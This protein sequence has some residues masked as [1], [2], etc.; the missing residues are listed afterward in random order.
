MQFL[1]GLEQKMKMVVQRASAHF[2]PTCWTIQ[3]DQLSLFHYDNLNKLWK[4]CLEN[5]QQPSVRGK[6][7]G[8]QTQTSKLSVLFNL[9]L[10]AHIL[11]ITDN[12][13]K[14]LHSYSLSVSEA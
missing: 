13:S 1:T 2:V 14:A 12:Q 8:V 11:K 9:K 5:S 6:I 7:I 4:K 3:D 10:C